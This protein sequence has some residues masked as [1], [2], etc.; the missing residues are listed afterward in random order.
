[1]FGVNLLKSFHRR[2]FVGAKDADIRVNEGSLMAPGRLR[3]ESQEYVVVG[4]AYA[5]A[6][7]VVTP[8]L[9]RRQRVSG[10]ANGRRSQQLTSMGVD[11]RQGCI[12]TESRGGKDR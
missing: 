5:P 12:R 4:G 11:I 3:D 9:T 7:E 10:R 1:M 6:W 2:L 8:I